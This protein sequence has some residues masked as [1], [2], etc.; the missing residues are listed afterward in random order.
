MLSFERHNSNLHP[1]PGDIY[2]KCA[3]VKAE[4]CPYKSVNALSFAG[5]VVKVVDNLLN[6]VPCKGTFHVK[7]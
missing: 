3:K 2:V 5:T 4:T 6:N 7:G 1:Q